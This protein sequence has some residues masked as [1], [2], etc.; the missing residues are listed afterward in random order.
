MKIYIGSLTAHGS[1]NILPEM[2]ANRNITQLFEKTCQLGLVNWGDTKV[3]C[4]TDCKEYVRESIKQFGYFRSIDWVENIEYLKNFSKQ[5][6][7]KSSWFGTYKDQLAQVKQLLNE[8]V[9]TISVNYNQNDH[10]FV[11][12]KWLKWQIAF[13][14]HQNNVYF[15]DIEEARKFFDNNPPSYDIPKEKNTPADYI[16]NI[17]DLY[18]YHK[19]KDFLNSVGCECSEEGWEFYR[20]Y[21]T[22][23]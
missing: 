7:P 22:Y 19:F 3:P 6:Y 18:D 14:M 8:D 12:E 23:H 1:A 4:H 11:Y 2:I 15:R 10:D 17:K 20:T 16:I 9:V 13:S 5:I 21:I